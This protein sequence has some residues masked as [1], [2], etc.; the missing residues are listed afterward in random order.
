M[1]EMGEVFGTDVP[2][3]FVGVEEF[4]RDRAIPNFLIA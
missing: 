2:G 1:S 3:M 4:D